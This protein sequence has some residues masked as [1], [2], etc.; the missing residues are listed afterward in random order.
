MDVGLADNA[1]SAIDE[2]LD[3]ILPSFLSIVFT[4]DIAVCEQ[5]GRLSF[6]DMQN[7][8]DVVKGE[9]FRILR[10]QCLLFFCCHFDCLPFPIEKRLGLSSSLWSARYSIRSA[11]AIRYEPR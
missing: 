2:K 7:A 10:S 1:V 8:T 9:L 6:A 3:G 4:L 11:L 5:P